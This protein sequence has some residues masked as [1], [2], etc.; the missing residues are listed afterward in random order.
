MLLELMA[1]PDS[2]VVESALSSVPAE[3]VTVNG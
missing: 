1:A 3:S 2:T